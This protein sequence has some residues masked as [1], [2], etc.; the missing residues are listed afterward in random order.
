MTG[1]TWV[2]WVKNQQ[3]LIFKLNFLFKNLLFIPI[4]SFIF[5]ILDI[6]S[7]TS[8][9]VCFLNLGLIFSTKFNWTQVQSYVFIKSVYSVGC[10]NLCSKSMVML[11]VVGWAKKKIQVPELVRLIGSVSKCEKMVAF[12]RWP[13][14]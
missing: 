14:Q 4:F 3:N 10:A 13:E 11:G 5:R 8:K 1:T 2:N 12:S 6:S 7:A 9:K